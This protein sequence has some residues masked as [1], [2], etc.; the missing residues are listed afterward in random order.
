MVPVYKYQTPYSRSTSG[1]TRSSF[2]DGASSSSSSSFKFSPSTSLAT[3]VRTLCPAMPQRLHRKFD[4]VLFLVLYRARFRIRF[5]FVRPAFLF[6]NN[7]DKIVLSGA[8]WSM[9]TVLKF[10]WNRFLSCSYVCTG[11]TCSSNWSKEKSRW[12]LNSATSGP[13]PEP[14]KILVYEYIK[15]LETFANGNQNMTQ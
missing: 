3:Q 7:G 13:R 14:H 15:S 9:H 10:L 2:A 6:L 8:I 12:I 5:F 4:N 11:F 1:I